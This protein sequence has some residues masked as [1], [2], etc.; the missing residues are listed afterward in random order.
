MSVTIRRRDD[1]K[2]YTLDAVPTAT[3]SRA[4]AVTMYPV[5]EGSTLTDHA[6]R[7]PFEARLDATVTETPIGDPII[8]NGVT[9][10][11]AARGGGRAGEG[12]LRDAIAFLEGS[13]GMELEIVFPR[14]AVIGPVMLTGF[15]FP[16]TAE[17]RLA[18][19]L[20][21]REV[22]R[23]SARSISMPRVNAPKPRNPDFEAET[24]RGTQPTE[25]ADR[26]STLRMLTSFFGG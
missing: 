20:S 4:I 12:R 7:L 26:R 10:G 2:S 23:V 22:R 13:V 17:K 9:V 5:E 14:I 11:H 3:L 19:D 21:V 6:R 18:L 16:I 8:V 15:S 1:G 24:D 25:A